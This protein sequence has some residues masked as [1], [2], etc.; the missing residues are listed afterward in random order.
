MMATVGWKELMEDVQEMY[1]T[2]NKVT[3]LGETNV[4]FRKGQLDILAWLLSLQSVS[5]Q[6]Y[7][8]LSN[9]AIL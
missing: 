2:Y 6:T 3:G 5:G 1:D 7:E 8:E 4:E 9:E